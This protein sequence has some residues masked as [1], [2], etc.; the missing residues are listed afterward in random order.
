MRLWF[1]VPKRCFLDGTFLDSQLWVWRYTFEK[2]W[3]TELTFF[4]SSAL[5]CKVLSIPLHMEYFE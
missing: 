3:A 2:I 4:S 5:I 1:F